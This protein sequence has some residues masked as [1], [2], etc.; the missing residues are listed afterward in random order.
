MKFRNVLLGVLALAAAPAA[1]I[2]QQDR[3]DYNE[4]GQKGPV[5]Q[6][7]AGA[8][9]SED[10]AKVVIL[11]GADKR[12][13][14][15]PSGDIL[16]IRYDG[17]PPEMNVARNHERGKRWDD[18]LFAYSDALKKVPADR[19]FLQTEIRFRRARIAAVQAE[20]SGGARRLAIA[21]LRNFKRDFPESRQILE[22]LELLSRLLLIDG[23]SRQEVVDAFRELRK[24]YG[25]SKEVS[26]KADLFE[27][28]LLLEDGQSLLVKGSRDE[29]KK[30]YAEAQAKLTAMVANAEKAGQLDLRISLAEC[31][32]VLD[33]A[34]EALKEL[35]AL[36]TQAGDDRTR[37]A[38]HL[39]RGDCHRLTGKFREAMWDY[40][41]V[42]AVYNEDREKQA[43]AVYY[44]HDIFS[45][46]LPEMANAKDYAR[47][48]QDR[49]K[50]QARLQDTYYGKLFAGR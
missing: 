22:C 25:Q 19:K 40:L 33:K 36:L 35:D 21:E 18:A 28:Q 42:D 10:P 1:A 2:A 11:A 30:K 46:R 27:T 48:C 41:W 12:Q 7:S 39:G 24:K 13:R 14:E 38:V 45:N 26:A 29:A 32:A 34:D 6:T 49:L 43:K 15:I 3:V 23:E 4:R 20:S 8:I 37:A 31:K 44:L 47:E 16:E 17:E 5:R 50:T 9:R